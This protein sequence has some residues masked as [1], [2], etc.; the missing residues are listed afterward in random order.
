[1]QRITVKGWGKADVTSAAIAAYL[2]NT[3]V[4]TD[5]ICNACSPKTTGYKGVPYIRSDDQRWHIAFVE[6]KNGRVCRVFSKTE[7]QEFE[8]SEFTN[9]VWP[10]GEIAE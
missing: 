8:V 2:N 1:M 9:D 6:I 3:W 7:F 10:L 5:Y 4:R